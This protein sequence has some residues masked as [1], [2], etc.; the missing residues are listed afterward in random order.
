MPGGYDGAEAQRRDEPGHRLGHAWQRQRGI[1][2]GI[3]EAVAGQIGRDDEEMLRQ[4]RRQPAPGMRR[5][6]RAMQQQQD[7]RIG[8]AELLKVPA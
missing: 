1:A 2:Q 6:P 7:R 8:S 4:Q 5:R 3:A